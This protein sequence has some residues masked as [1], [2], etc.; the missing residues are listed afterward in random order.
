MLE[1][2]RRELYRFA[3]V[4]DGMHEISEA[5]P[6]GLRACANRNGDGLLVRGNQRGSL[7]KGESA[8]SRLLLGRRRPRACHMIAGRFPDICGFGMRVSS[9]DDAN[10]CS[11]SPTKPKAPFTL[12]PQ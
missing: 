5:C 4:T 8:P 7:G 11:A 2:S 12:K 9:V 3:D 1:D 6:G 10:V